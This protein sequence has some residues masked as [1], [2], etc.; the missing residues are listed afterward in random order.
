MGRGVTPA[1]KTPEFLE[2]KIEK[3]NIFVVTTSLLMHT[4]CIQKRI[5]KSHGLL[6]LLDSSITGFTSAAYQPSHLLGSFSGA[7]RRQ[8]KPNLGA[9]FALRCFQCLS[10]PDVATLQCR[11]RDNRYTVGP[12]TPVL[13]Y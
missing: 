4:M 9:G 3:K 8:G 7:L 6:V 13:S 5:G 11:W 12:F 10:H 1:I 2:S